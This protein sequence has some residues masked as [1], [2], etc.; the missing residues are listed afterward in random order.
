MNLNTVV[1]VGDRF[2]PAMVPPEQFFGG[3]VDPAGR[4][5][6]G[7]IA[8][9]GYDSGRCKF[10]LH[11]SRIDL[12]VQSQD[13][14]P[15]KLRSAAETLLLTLDKIR[16]AVDI[17]GLGLNCDAAIPTTTTTGLEI[18]NRL[19]TLDL[20]KEITGASSLQVNTV[21]QYKIGPLAYTLRIEPEARSNGQN[22]FVAVNGHQE[23]DPSSTLTVKLN[24][25]A[26]FR[27]HVKNL[28][29]S[30]RRTFL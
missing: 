17:S 15:E 9:F 27:N 7:P 20:L 28:H 8:Q 30:I 10:S 21:S 16:T 19:A 2:D 23:V 13:V 25:F 18:S 14:M 24:E 3:A 29:D 22:L 6:I 26:S 11:P 12:S 1:V 4:I 5:M